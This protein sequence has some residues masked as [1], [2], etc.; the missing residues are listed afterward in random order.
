MSIKKGIFGYIDNKPVVKYDIELENV[1]CSFSEVGAA[2]LEYKVKDKNGVYT[3]VVLGYDTVEEYLHN[4]P[5]FGAVVGRFANRVKDAKF[6]LNGVEYNLTVNDNANCLHSGYSYHYRQWDSKAY[7]DEQG[8][9]LIYTIHSNHLDQGYPGVLDVEL[10]YLIEPNGALTLTYTYMADQE[11]PVSLTNH[12]YFNLNGHNSGTAINHELKLVSEAVTQLDEELIPTGKVVPVKGSALDFNEL[13]VI[14]ENMKKNFEGYCH[15]N[16][17][18]INY[19]LQEDKGEFKYI[20]SLV[21]DKSGICMNMYT[22]LPGI[23]FYSGNFLDEKGKNN[24]KYDK[25]F[26]LCFETQFF[27]NSVNDLTFPSPFIKPFTKYV[28]KTKYEFVIKK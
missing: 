5:G 17:Y 9:H 12:C 10:E 24:S 11:T 14:S 25:H 18:D 1:I 7:L 26:G 4:G 15:F 13:T 20:G 19:I 8:A 22:D 3:D 27:P 21:G 23:Q 16:A 2:I 6:S 28:S